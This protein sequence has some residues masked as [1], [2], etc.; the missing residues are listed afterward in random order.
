MT[1]KSSAAIALVPTS[2]P[3]VSQ[4]IAALNAEAKAMAADHLTATLAEMK[5]L[6]DDLADVAAAEIGV[7]PGI[8][9]RARKLSDSLLD[10]IE[11]IV[12]LRNRVG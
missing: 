12:G 8:K 4:K 9:E 1:Q 3:T 5:K 10:E 7:S 6:S 11:Q 2:E